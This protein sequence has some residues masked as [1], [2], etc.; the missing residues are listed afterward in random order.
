MAKY[1]A[2]PPADSDQ[3][4]VTD[5]SFYEFFAGGGMARAGLGS[6][7]SC[8]FAN[9]FDPMKARVYEDNWGRGHLR[10]EDVATM[11][12]AHLPGAPD[13]VWASF[14][15]Q[16]L[17]LAGDYRGLG[18]DGANDGTRSGAFWSFWRLMGRLRDEQR[19]PPLV[20]L[21]NVLGVL[22]ANGGQD[23]QAI[24][25]ALAQSGYRFGAVVIDARWFVPQSRPRVFLVAV[26]DSID[27][28]ADLMAMGPSERWSPPILRTAHARLTPALAK[29]WVWWR[30]GEPQGSAPRLADV[31]EELPQGAA[32]HDWD[33][34]QKLLD[35]MSPSNLQKVEEAKAAGRPRVGAL[36]R[37]TRPNGDG[38]RFVRAEVRFDDVAGCLRTPAGGSSRQNLLMVEGDQVRSRLLSPR[39]AARLMGL[40]DT[41]RLPPSAS[42]AYRVVGD[43]VVVPVVRHL[44][45]EL[46]EPLARAARRTEAATFAAE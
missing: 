4:S 44:A 9:D 15:C 11:A 12:P 43:G 39:E 23:F 24:A 38:G 6:A 31:L 7:W 17:S 32:W 27:V 45:A 22:T 3:S 33:Q 10:C 46:L 30:L 37:R 16:D 40:P 19:A 26:R 13:L 20:V 21:E 42:D 35:S 36:Y 1:G 5:L 25:L 14:P 34:T 29:R 28:P 8:L 41:Y 2:R 18:R